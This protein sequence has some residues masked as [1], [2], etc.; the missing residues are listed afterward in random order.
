[1]RDIR[2]LLKTHYSNSRALVIGI[3]EYQN[4]PPLSY[5]V[6]DATEIRDVLIH[7]LSFPP[8]N[9]TCLFDEEATRKNILKTYLSFTSEDVEPDERIIVFFAGHG[10]TRSGYKGEVGYLV[11]SDADISDF[12]SFIRWDDLTRNADLI[13]AKHMLFIMDACYGGLALTRN[14][15][16][17]SSRFLKDMMLRYSRQVLTAGKADEVVADSGGPLPD[18]SVFTGHLIEGLRGKAFTEQ[19]VLTASSLMAYVYGKV[20][21]DKDSN[22]TPHHGHFDG[23]GDVILKA[24]GLEELQQAEEID[25]DRLIA[26][27]YPE[28][29][30]STDSTEYKIAKAKKYLSD[31]SYLIELHDFVI[32]EIR[33]FNSESGEDKFSVQINYSEGEFL[34]RISKYEAI[35]N[36][37]ALLTACISYWAKNSHG[38]IIQKIISRLT[39]N[40][41][42]RGGTVVWLTLRWYPLIIVLYCS[43][44]AAISSG[45]FGSL[46]YIF[47]AVFD[48]SEYDQNET[49]FVEAITSQIS[50]LGRV[51]IF[52]KL[53]GHEK[54]FVPMSEYLFKTIQPKLDDTF[55]LGRH[56]ERAFDEFEV[57]FA[58]THADISKQKGHKA[59]GPIGRFGWKHSRSRNAPLKRMIEEA[60]RMGDNWEPLKAGLFG[61]QLSRFTSVA[62]EFESIVASL[63]W[64]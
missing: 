55:F 38:P 4:A 10:Q 51:E 26:I 57:L 15:L 20:A 8:D 1:M 60:Q 59:W 23:D 35:I 19:G 58:L 6:S 53:P 54:N 41:V 2:F 16:S 27:P 11:P 47:N 44:I 30:H 31:D 62:E 32:D 43:G 64:R 40:V 29:D 3:N 7:E 25:L 21:T 13:R 36:D 42:S 63:H 34:T 9:I 12:S 37:V 22:Q 17:G 56:F 61:G 45:R 5:A 49:L 18:H 52:K 48:S 33:R 46:K 50:E 28:E 24:P 39:D 14:A